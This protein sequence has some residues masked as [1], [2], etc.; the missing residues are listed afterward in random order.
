MKVQLIHNFNM[1]TFDDVVR[2]LE[3]ED[4]RIQAIK[5][6]SNA[7]VAKTSEVGVANSKRK[8]YGGK[9]GKKGA[10]KAQKKPK[11]DGKE[12]ASH[13][14]KKKDKSKLKCYNCGNKGHFA[15]ECKEEKKVL[16]IFSQ[17][18][19]SYVSSSVFMSELFFS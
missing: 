13:P 11:K 3:L 2:H 10:G 17:N 16:S 5:S 6:E 19:T 15:Q 12:D 9:K 14:K 1:T 18:N 4:E 7:Y 8:H